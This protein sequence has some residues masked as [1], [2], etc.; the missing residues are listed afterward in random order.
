MTAWKP[1]QKAQFDVELLNFPGPDKPWDRIAQGVNRN[2]PSCKAYYQFLKRKGLIS[3]SEA[4]ESPIYR[5][6]VPQDTALRWKFDDENLSI[7]D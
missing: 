3:E 4:T 5:L 6:P 7:R 2:K 1:W